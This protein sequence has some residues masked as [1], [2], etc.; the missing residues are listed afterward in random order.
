MTLVPFSSSVPGRQRTGAGQCEVSEQGGAA[1]LGKSL[2]RNAL[3][4]ISAE[5]R[6]LDLNGKPPVYA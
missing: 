4:A 2:R 3:H 1:P 5:S 6:N